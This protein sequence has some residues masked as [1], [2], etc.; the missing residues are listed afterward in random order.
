MQHVTNASILMPWLRAVTNKQLTSRYAA[1]ATHATFRLKR[2][3]SRC[4]PRPLNVQTPCVLVPFRPS[5]ASNRAQTAAVT[6]CGHV[7][8]RCGSNAPLPHFHHQPLHVTLTRRCV[9]RESILAWLAQ[10]AAKVRRV[11]HAAPARRTSFTPP[12][13]LPAV[14]AK[15]Q[16]QGVRCQRARAPRSL[17]RIPA[18]SASAS[19]FLPNSLRLLNSR[20]SSPVHVCRVQCHAEH[21]A[22]HPRNGGRLTFMKQNPV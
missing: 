4:M 7:F 11:E 15:M 17:F 20:R 8:H 16:N 21:A 3:S 12:P 22:Q 6:S 14:P 1:T 13:G 2:Y 9:R 10:S 19:L 5:P 18:Q